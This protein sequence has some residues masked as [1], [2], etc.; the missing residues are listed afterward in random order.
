MLR[1]MA[2]GV[3]EKAVE[4]FWEFRPALRASTVVRYTLHDARVRNL[5]FRRPMGP[6][7]PSR[8][9]LLPDGPCAP[10]QRR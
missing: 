9:V 2:E 4:G 10:C 5:S 3:L 6:E 7:C 8:Q 1:Q